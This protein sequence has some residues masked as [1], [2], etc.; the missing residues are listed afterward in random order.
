MD[1]SPCELNEVIDLSDECECEHRDPE[2]YSILTNNSVPF[3][4]ILSVPSLSEAPLWLQHYE[5]RQINRDATMSTRLDRVEA[6]LAFLSSQLAHTNRSNESET[7]DEASEMP[8]GLSAQSLIE[9][10]VMAG[11]NG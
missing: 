4:P 7:Y 6:A 5:A 3:N 10:G 9:H 11:W 2:D 8:S 1:K